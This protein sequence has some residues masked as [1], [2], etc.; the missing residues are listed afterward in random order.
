MLI[1]A[2]SHAT[3]DGVR[4]SDVESIAIER[5]SE[6]LVVE[7]VDTSRDPAFADV[8]R[9][10]TTI[11]V[12]CLLRKGA[13][14]SPIDPSPGTLGTLTFDTGPTE[15]VS[16]PAAMVVGVTYQLGALPK[17]AAAR[18]TIE[19][20]LVSPSGAVVLSTSTIGGVS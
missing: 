6:Q 20:L 10:R 14:Q 7:F 3:F 9:R 17:G 8:A 12:V 16:A 4:I 5:T 15:R 18:R 2:P 19:F 11:K 13:E 1:I